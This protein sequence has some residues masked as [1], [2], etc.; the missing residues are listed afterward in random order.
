M[1][2]HTHTDKLTNVYTHVQTER[3]THTHRHTADTCTIYCCTR[4]SKRMWFSR[5]ISNPLQTNTTSLYN[6]HTGLCTNR[7]IQLHYTMSILDF[8]QTD[9]Y[10]F[11]I[12]CLYWTLYKMFFRII[13]LLHSDISVCI[14]SVCVCMRARGVSMCVYVCAH[15]V[16]LSVCARAG[17]VF[18]CVCVCVHVC[19][20][21]C[22]YL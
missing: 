7:Q 11:T 6:V 1:C 16:C 21:V 20:R 2:T 18:V 19:V 5:Y 12:Q 4:G 13:I 8:V 14:C 22:V 15:G 9:K 10:N 3:L 17:C